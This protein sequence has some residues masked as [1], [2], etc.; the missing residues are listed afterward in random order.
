MREDGWNLNI[1]TTFFVLSG[2]WVSLV[3]PTAGDAG[4]SSGRKTPFLVIFLAS[5]T[6]TLKCAYFFVFRTTF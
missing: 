3:P 2:S 5:E 6:I 1:K 4:R